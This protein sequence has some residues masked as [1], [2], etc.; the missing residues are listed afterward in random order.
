MVEIMNETW[1]TM[2]VNFPVSERNGLPL[3]AHL[4]HKILV[5]VKHA[6]AIVDKDPRSVTSQRIRSSSPSDSEDQSVSA[7]RK[8]ET[9]KSKIIEALSALGVYTSGYHFKSLN[10]P[11]AQIPTHVFSLSESKL[12][13]VHQNSGPLLFSHNRNFLMRAFPSGMR[14]SS[15]NLDPAIFWRKGVQMVALNWQ[16]LDAGMMLNEGMFAGGDGWILKPKGYREQREEGKRS[17]EHSQTD[18]ITHKSLD[19]TIE[20]FGGQDIPLPEE[21][22]KAE[23]FHPYLKCELHVEK[24]EERT[25][26]PIEGGGRSKDGEHKRRTKSGKGV[27]PDFGGESLEFLKITEV[28]EELSFIRLVDLFSRLFF[29]ALW[30]RT[31]VCFSISPS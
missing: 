25:G 10:G 13:E 31:R 17:F 8:T 30:I 19:L 18:A 6:G 11:E 12:M 4:K 24:P 23:S 15:S 1:K 28:A 21:G 22:D 20:V 27:E 5:K 16:K 9:R 26:A 7:D 14:V 2:L 3:L 29:T